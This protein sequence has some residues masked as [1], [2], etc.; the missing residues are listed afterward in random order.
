[1]ALGRKLLTQP[2]YWWPYLAAL[3][4]LYLIFPRWFKEKAQQKVSD[5]TIFIQFK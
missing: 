3:S 2:K 5:K 1:M 4:K